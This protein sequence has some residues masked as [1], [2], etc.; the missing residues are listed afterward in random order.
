M[1]KLAYTICLLFS[2]GLT[3]QEK[4][5]EITK[6]S[7]PIIFDG[8]I[9]EPIWLNASSFTLTRQ[10]PDYGTK[11][12]EITEVRMVYDS[13]FIYVAT[14]LF[15]KNTS[16]IQDFS[17]QRDAGGP[18]DYMAFAFDGYSD[19]TN[20]QAFATTP[21]GLRWDAALTF[22]S[23]G[24]SV[25]D[26]WN[27]YWEVKVSNDDKGWYA[28]FKI[29]LSSLRFKTN[30]DEVLMNFIVWR[31]IA[32][33]NEFSVFPDS[34]PDFGVYSFANISV[35]YPIKFKRIKN[36]N[37][38]YVTPYSLGGLSGDKVL[39]NT[40][41]GFDTASKSIVEAGVDFKYSLSSEL[42]LDATINTDFAQVESDNFQVNLSR[43]SLFFPEKRE[44]FL[45]RTNNF[46]FTF[47]N[48]NDVFYSR[49]I[50]L[51]NGELTRI[52]GGARLVGRIGKWD[53]GF[54]NMQ[55]EDK[56]NNAS[57]NIGLLRFKKQIGKSNSYFGGI[58][59][60]SIGDQSNQFYTYGLDAQFVLPLKSFFKIA[61]AKSIE[62]TVSN[63]L[64]SSENLRFNA[65]IELPSQAGLFYSFGHSII[66]N[67][68]NPVLGFE[69]RGNIKSYNSNIGYALFEKKSKSIFKH[70]LQWTSY[71]ID[72]FL[73][74]QKESLGSE[75]L[76]YFELKIGAGVDIKPYYRE[77]NLSAPLVLS[78]R[79]S[80]PI[81]NYSFKAINIFLYSPT[82]KSIHVNSYIDLGT[83][84]NGYKTSFG[85]FG[86]FDKSKFIQFQ[87]N[88]KYDRV[89]FDQSLPSFEN[90]LASFTTLLNFDTKLSI[91]G[92]AQYDDLSKKIGTNIRLRYNTKEGNDLYLVMTNINNTD[93]YRQ[94]PTLPALQSWLFIAKYKHT[95]A[96]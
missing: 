16:E 53:I 62:N 93:V 41:T 14:K 46:S 17:K 40:N 32:S 25:N 47:D 73:T 86:R 74:N 36:S 13:K 38:M 2:I 27:T 43:S 69:E 88:Y 67:K 52:Y 72:G 64:S 90:H 92:L 71:K 95:F 77:E 33:K 80:I 79:V 65:K 39:N 19:K 76:Y 24:I 28:E 3:A 35:G 91:S 22:D 85:F 50:G 70:T 82:A 34:K 89:N 23:K 15:H 68:Y 1:H 63:T 5:I 44:F 10:S 9:N 87:M 48:N 83:F 59:T 4:P 81:G 42:T 18:N 37:P 31:K 57:K 6:I 7:E 51:D 61:T 26:N 20:G 96:F 12:S 21:A 60:S 55:T 8:I 58:F 30:Q 56:I 29:P 78:D 54:L 11:P 94:V 75:L 84:Y 49:R 66:G 45:E